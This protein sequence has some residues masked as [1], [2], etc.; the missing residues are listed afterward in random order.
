MVRCN[1]TY[2]TVYINLS[3]IDININ[4]DIDIDIDIDIEIYNVIIK[5]QN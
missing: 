5:N 4:I 1:F 2:G 3:I